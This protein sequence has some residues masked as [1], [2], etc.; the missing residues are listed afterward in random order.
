MIVVGLGLAQSILALPRVTKRAIALFVDGGI[1]LFTLWIAL[2][3]QLETWV[4]WEGNLWWIALLSVSLYAPIFISFGLYRAI[5]RYSGWR[6]MLAVV[7]AIS[8]YGAVFTV[9]FTVI[10]VQGVP[11]SIGIIHPLLLFVSV[12][13]SRAIV[14]YWLG[15]LYHD[16]LQRQ[17]WPGVMIYGVGSAGRQLQRALSMAP[18]YRPVGYL[19]DDSK[20]QG[21]LVDGWHVYSPK[22]LPDLIEPLGV[23]DLLLAMPSMHRV[24]PCVRI[25]VR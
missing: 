7:K 1:S 23:S 9:I 18:G 11:R 4:I 13:G 6:A 10:G 19:D 8:V 20:L 24:T 16:S 14:R 5:F 12:G 3:I 22:E 17:K 21:Q 15:G 2:C 25:E